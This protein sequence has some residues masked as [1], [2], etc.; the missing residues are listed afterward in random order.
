MQSTESTFYQDLHLHY[1]KLHELIADEQ[2]F[3]KVPHSW[4]IVVT[5]VENSTKAVSE[6]KQQVV[7]LAATGS[8]VACLNISREGGIE[9]PF[10]FG[11]DGATIIVPDEILEE[12]LFALQLHQERCSISFDFYLR[13]GHRKVGAMI[14]QGASLQ[15]L[16]YKRNDLHIMPVILGNALQMAEAEIKSANQKIPAKDL[17]YNLNLEGMECKWDK[18]KPPKNEN[19][20]LTLII[21]STIVEEQSSVYSNVL[22]RIDDIYGDDSIRHPVTAKRLKMVHK[23]SRLKNEVKMKFSHL[24][25]KKLAASWWRSVMGSWFTKYT[26]TGRD[27]LNDL[28]QLTETLLIDGAINT[29]IS[30]KKKQR[31]ELL[32]YLNSLEAQGSI[33][34][35]FYSSNSSILSCFVTAIDDYHIHFLDGD[36]GGYTQASK[37]LKP[38]LRRQ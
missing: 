36:N 33:V 11:G 25:N 34:Y 8:I 37:V 9:I 18:I 13:V 3:S 12:C 28:I 17:P 5:D 6:G 4:N 10:F 38:K 30:G 14:E 35:G 22:E 1:G 19:E 27:Y 31:E 20:I 16:K 7:N 29:V 24:T 21:Q 23:L 26:S 32:E 15:I 2:V